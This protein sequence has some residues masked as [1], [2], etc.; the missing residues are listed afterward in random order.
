MVVFLMHKVPRCYFKHFTTLPFFLKLC[1]ILW[2]WQFY[3]F[4]SHT[5]YIISISWRNWDTEMINDLP[6][7]IAC[8][9]QVCIHRIRWSWIGCRVCTLDH[10]LMMSREWH[11]L[12]YLVSNCTHGL[13]A[14]WMSVYMLGIQKK[15]RQI[16]SLPSWNFCSGKEDSK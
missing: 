13:F 9:F 5:T 7:V 6:K 14:T 12:T 16:R 15:T 4:S 8:Y 11:L 2:Q 1:L 10:H 3:K